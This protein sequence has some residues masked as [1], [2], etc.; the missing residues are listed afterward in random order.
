MKYLVIAFIL[1]NTISEIN[2][3]KNNLTGNYKASYI[4]NRKDYKKY[5]TDPS[6]KEVNYHL[7]LE[8]I[9]NK[10]TLII[11]YDIEFF[12]RKAIKQFYEHIIVTS[13]R[14][15]T[16][17]LIDIKNNKEI[18]YIKGSKLYYK[19]YNQDLTFIKSK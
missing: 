19:G 17:R 13:K 6:I 5:E 14:R 15:N 11:E 10:T 1:F 16:Y 12:E 3:Q 9:K 7:N 2:A 18:G 4:P 8:K